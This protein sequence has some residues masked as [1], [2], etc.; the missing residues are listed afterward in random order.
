M[1]DPTCVVEGCVKA[2]HAKG[3]C[4]QHYQRRWR[5]APDIVARPTECVECHSVMPPSSYGKVPPSYCSKSCRS[6]ASYRRRKAD[7]KIP[8]KPHVPPRMIRCGHCGDEFEA[9]R[10]D[11]RY[12][13]KRCLGFG[14]RDSTSKQC[15]A[16]DCANPVRARGMCAKH[17]RRWARSEGIEKVPEW[18]PERRARWKAREVAK[19]TRGGQVEPIDAAIIFERDGWACRICGLPVDS[20]LPYPDPMSKSLDHVMPLSRGGSHTPANVQLAHLF[21]NLSKGARVPA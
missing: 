12:C 8:A 19:R 10:S 5:G 2:P 16:D 13:S 21:C 9:T 4:S 7:G 6:K 20:A 11:A 15:T 3:L 1:S 17:Y 14:S 18:T